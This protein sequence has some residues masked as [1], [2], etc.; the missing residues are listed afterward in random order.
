LVHIIDANPDIQTEVALL[1]LDSSTQ[2][3]VP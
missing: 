3:S 2:H 1:V